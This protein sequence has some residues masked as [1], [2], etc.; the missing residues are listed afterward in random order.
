MVIFFLLCKNIFWKFNKYIRWVLYYPR[1]TVVYNKDWNI[2]HIYNSIQKILKC[3]IKRVQHFDRTCYVRTTFS[4]YYRVNMKILQKLIQQH[5]E[6]KALLSKGFW[7]FL[8]WNIIPCFTITKNMKTFYS[9]LFGVWAC[10]FILS[11]SSIL[12]VYNTDFS[13]L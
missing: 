8:F 7:W 6:V 12:L 2:I 11:V 4:T 9:F 3:R 5:W 10:F 13:R 1:C